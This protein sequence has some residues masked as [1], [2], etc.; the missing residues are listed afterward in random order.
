M[1][2]WL[3]HR[4]AR[5]L[6]RVPALVRLRRS[7][8][9]EVICVCCAGVC[10]YGECA[11]G[12]DDMDEK[13][14]DGARPAGAFAKPAGAFFGRDRSDSVNTRPPIEQT[15]KPKSKGKGKVSAKSKAKK[16]R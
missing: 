12:D 11:D 5:A 9:V 3:P 10:A 16:K 2:G 15:S 8:H 13:H 6:A 14:K 1:A 4:R 7:A